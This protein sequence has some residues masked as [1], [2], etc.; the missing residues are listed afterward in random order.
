MTAVSPTYA[1]EISGHPAI[2]PHLGKF[3]GIRNGIDVDIWDPAADMFLPMVSAWVGQSPS[4]CCVTGRFSWLLR[5]G[6]HWC[7]CLRPSISIST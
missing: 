6:S 2:A 5:H 7:P 1:S 3:M 4:T